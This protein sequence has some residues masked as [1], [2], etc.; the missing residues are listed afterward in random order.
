M[1][2]K[3]KLNNNYNTKEKAFYIRLIVFFLA[4]IFSFSTD[5]Q[6]SKKRIKELLDSIKIAKEDTNKFNLYYKLSDKYL[7]SNDTIKSLEF[8]N[9]A[10]EL[11]SKINYEIGTAKANLQ[12]G[13][14][15]TYQ[16]LLAIDKSISHL[17]ISLKIFENL[18]RTKGIAD[19]YYIIGNNYLSLKNPEAAIENLNMAINQYKKINKKSLIADC[20]IM[21]GQ[22]YEIEKKYEK[23][24]SNFNIALK[25][26]KSDNDTFNVGATYYYMGDTY[27]MEKNY[28]TALFYHEESRKISLI[29][30]DSSGVG[31]SYMRIGEIFYKQKNLNKSLENYFL[32]S[33]YFQTPKDSEILAWSYEQIALTYRNQ[34]QYNLS[35][36]FYKK[37]EKIY[38]NLNQLKINFGFYKGMSETYAKLNDFKSAY[39]YKELH[40]RLYDSVMDYL[41]KMKNKL[42]NTQVNYEL[43]KSAKERE[44]SDQL[45]SEKEDKI[46]KQKI[47]NYS[48]IGGLIIL[49]AF[50]FWIFKSRKKTRKQNALITEQ[51]T[52]IE[53]KHKEI[54][55]SINY[56][57]RIQRSFLATKTIL[58]EHLKDYFVFFKP[59]DVVSGDFYW[60]TKLS[61]GNFTLCTADSTGHG[62]PGAIMSIL[63]ISSLEKASSITNEP[64]EILN[65]TRKII[66]SRLKNDGSS[67]GG[68]DGMDCSL[69]VFDKAKNKITYAAAN[70]PIWIIRKNE[71]GLAELVE[72][73][74][75]KMPVGKHERDT[76]PFLQNEIELLKGDVIYT[77]TDGMPDQF[78]GPKGKKYK[79]AKLKEFL[80]A[81]SD[82]PMS[83][84]H[85]KIKSEFENWKGELEQ[86]DDVTLIGIKA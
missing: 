63:N 11:S 18:K 43:E 81:I 73:K 1:Y 65:L 17:L 8:S 34:E 47:I 20:S 30:K 21:I 2:N 45:I 9:K 56:A 42:E 58:D 29:L 51:K 5:A 23:T 68:K 3:E 19:C 48:F 59:K 67:E 6:H 86:V 15:Y 53:E 82:L 10:L 79:Y 28:E 64:N 12:I 62:V 25:I 27:L 14:L 13:Y 40:S 38:E 22:A 71:K 7:E 83:K 72:I 60:G 76:I 69:I 54:T 57:E 36:Q 44:L 75:D 32:A 77:L 4:F 49:S 24:L 70:N 78:G 39:F 33:K 55:D 41:L 35:I 66:I 31:D 16:G 52:L 46:K 50:L 37:A 84:Q 74:P 61:N 85:E 26:Y 80:F